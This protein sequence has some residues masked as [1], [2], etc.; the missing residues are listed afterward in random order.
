MEQK[1]LVKVVQLRLAI[2]IEQE[3]QAVQ[4]SLFFAIP[5]H[6]QFHLAQV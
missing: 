1:I 4:V 2:T 6:E 5:T 3:T